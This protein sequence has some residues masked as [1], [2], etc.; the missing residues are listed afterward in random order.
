MTNRPWS[1][2]TLDDFIMDR[3][4]IQKS[5]HEIFT[6]GSPINDRDLFRGRLGQ[7]QRILEAVPSPGRHPVI[8]GQ[9][10]VGKT[11]FVNILNAFLPN[12]L[13]IK[14]TCDSSDTFKSIW[15]RVL[16][17]ATISFKEKAFGF[18]RA[19]S[20]EKSSLAAFL[21]RDNGV[22]PSEVAGILQYL[23]NPAM[24][25]LD[26]FDR[27][28]DENVK[29]A[30]ADLIKNVSDNNSNV[31]L[32]LVGVGESITE[33]IGE[34]ESIARNLAQIE[35]PEM[36]PAEIQE[37][38]TKGC[39]R[40]EITPD[41]SVL[42]EVASLSAGFPHYAHLLGLCIAKAC[43]IHDTESIDIEL[44]EELACNLAVEDA[45]ETYRQS[46]TKATRTSQASRYPKILCACG[47]AVHDDNGVFRA[48]DVVEAMNSLFD[49]PVT[50]Q[51]VVPALSVFTQPERGSVLDKVPVGKVTH[52]RFREPMMRPFLKIKAKTL[53][54]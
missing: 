12:H 19:E 20:E 15:N 41:Q 52:Y 40:L 27:V 51:A 50:L 2:E 38:I 16:Q 45:I 3:T 14:V 9:R 53:N 43:F 42:D 7:I 39:S 24:F 49:E 11:S 17:K 13:T 32:I 4:T 47:A 48:T 33:L 28:L 34:H 10:G 36:K 8:F 44:F 29:T 5:M 21:G 26:E 54:S 30:T 22:S 46:F 31:T 35:M 18:S 23:M 6:P 37:I 1:L 25:I